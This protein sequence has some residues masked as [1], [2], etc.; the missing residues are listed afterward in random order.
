[1]VLYERSA[2]D[3]CV[4]YGVAVSSDQPDRYELTPW[5]EANGRGIVR[6]A[7]MQDQGASKGSYYYQFHFSDQDTAFWFRMRFGG[8]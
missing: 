6:M 3:D 2:P 7:V 4:P 8:K 1:M 5:L